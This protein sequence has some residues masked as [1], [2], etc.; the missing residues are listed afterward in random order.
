MQ[1]YY[2]NSKHN[3]IK[4]GSYWNRKNPKINYQ[5]QGISGSKSSVNVSIDS[6]KSNNLY[7]WRSQSKE[8]SHSII[9]PHKKKN[10]WK[11][12]KSEMKEIESEIQKCVLNWWSVKITDS[13]VGVNYDLLWFGLGCHVMWCDVTDHL[14]SIVSLWK[15]GTDNAGAFWKDW[16][17]HG[18]LLQRK[19]SVVFLEI[20]IKSWQN[21]LV[22]CLGEPP[23]Q[24]EVYQLQKW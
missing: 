16:R 5:M 22:N 20:K 6:C 15:V 4:S 8:Y 18:W 13:R 17:I 9:Y 10:N 14:T 19:N 12:V 1:I 11:K 24:I 2:Q 21:D 23:L 7:L 3:F